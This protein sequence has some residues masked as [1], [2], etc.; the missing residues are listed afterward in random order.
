MRIA[1][2]VT[3]RQ[4]EYRNE[5]SQK[6]KRV[7]FTR[8]RP[9]I[10]LSFSVLVRFQ[11]NWPDIST[12]QLKIYIFFNPEEGVKRR[13][14]SNRFFSKSAYERCISDQ[15]LPNNTLKGAGGGPRPKILFYAVFVEGKQSYQMLFTRSKILILAGFIAFSKLQ[16]TYNYLAAAHFTRD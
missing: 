4:L 1:K 12:E 9:D 13:C 14:I 10:R 8:N 7:V 5:N 6:R 15:F 2:N 3:H 11:A 16:N